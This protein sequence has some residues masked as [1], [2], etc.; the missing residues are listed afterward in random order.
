MKSGKGIILITFQ[1]FL[2]RRIEELPNA[3]MIVNT[4]LK[5][6]I[7]RH[8]WTLTKWGNMSKSTHVYLARTC[9][10]VFI[11]EH[12]Y[13]FFNNINAELKTIF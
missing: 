7:E 1:V 4:A 12:I 11:D 10:I 3:A 6:R 13:A 2:H 9:L 8:F 5:L